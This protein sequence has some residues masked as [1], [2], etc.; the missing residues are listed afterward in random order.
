M[1]KMKTN[2]QKPK[3]PEFGKKCRATETLNFL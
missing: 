2:K 3:L 1:A